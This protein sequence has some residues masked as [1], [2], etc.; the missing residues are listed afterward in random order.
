MTPTRFSAA[1]SR[2]LSMSTATALLRSASAA[3]SAGSSTT[4]SIAQRTA[5]RAPAISSGAPSQSVRPASSTTRLAVSSD[6]AGYPGTSAPASP[7]AT[8]G[9]SGVPSVAPTPTR[10]VR[11]PPRLAARS[12]TSRAQARSG[13]AVILPLM[14]V[15][16]GDPP[17]SWS[18]RGS[19]RFPSGSR[20]SRSWRRARTRSGSRSARN[21]GRSPAR[22]APIR[23]RP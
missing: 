14:P 9:R 21:D 16:P 12:S 8:N 10:T 1:A 23:S 7:N 3:R 22:S 17:S 5:G 20:S 18:R 19:G 15:G 11:A 2:P 4:R 13:S 6:P